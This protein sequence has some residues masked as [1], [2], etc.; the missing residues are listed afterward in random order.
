VRSKKSKPTVEETAAAVEPN[1]P[2]STNPIVLGQQ[3]AATAIAPAV[4]PTERWRK[5]TKD[6]M[7]REFR[8]PKGEGRADAGSLDGLEASSGNVVRV[9][10]GAGSVTLADMESIS[11]DR[12]A[13]AAETVA[14]IVARHDDRTHLL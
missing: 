4:F 1:A 6:A 5:D 13:A 3:S 12:A 2:T 9:E 10:T 14:R 11:E 7:L 8:R